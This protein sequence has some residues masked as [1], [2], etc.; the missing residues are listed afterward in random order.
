MAYYGANGKIYVIGGHVDTVSNEASQT[1]EY[2][3]VANTWNTMRA[4]IPVAMGGSATSIVG[5]YIYLAGSYG[6]SATT[7]HYRYD[8]VGNSW[9]AMAPLPGARYDAAGAAVGN[10][11][12]VIGGGNPD[13][14]IGRAIAGAKAAFAPYTSDVTRLRIVVEP[15]DLNVVIWGIVSITDQDSR[16]ITVFP[17]HP[18]VEN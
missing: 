7:L 1:W 2:D 14:G 3:P 18:D 9:A 11:T 15:V 8:I 17:A 10:Q 13:F 12:Y 4:N 16:Q 5:Q 6:G